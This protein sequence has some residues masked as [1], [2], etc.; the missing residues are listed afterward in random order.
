M[1]SALDGRLEAWVPPKLRAEG[2]E[3]VR[4]AKLLLAMSWSML[5]WASVFLPV[6]YAM[7]ATTVAIS[8]AIATAGVS[9]VAPVLWW[10]EDI[11]WPARLVMVSIIEVL[12]GSAFALTGPA[13]PSLFW[14][15]AMP[16]VA[17]ALLGMKEGALWTVVSM[18]AFFVLVALPESWFGQELEGW[19]LTVYWCM[20]A[21]SGLILQF[22]LG[23]SYE[24][25]KDEMRG[26]LEVARD[27]AAD[28]HAAARLVLDHVNEGLMIVGR[29]GR[30]GSQS[31]SAT[32]HLLGEPTPGEPLWS[33]VERADPTAATWLELGWDGLVDGFMPPEVVLDQLP[34]RIQV[35][36]R[37]LGVAFSPVVEEDELQQVV[38]VLRDITEELERQRAEASQRELLAVFQQLLRDPGG[39]DLF[40][41]STDEMMENLSAMPAKLQMRA[42]HTLKGNA[43][44]LGLHGL[45]SVCHDVESLM[46]QGE[47]A[48][49]AGLDGVVEAWA[50][51][52]TRLA[53]LRPDRDGPNVTQEDY[54]TLF[55]AVENGVPHRQLRDYLEGWRLEPVALPLQRA[56][57]Q[58]KMLAER[59][60]KPDLEVVLD[61]DELRVDAGQ[62]LPL[63]ASMAHA[64]RNAI[65]HGIEAPEQRE[66]AGK[67]PHGRLVLGFTLRGERAV[68]RIQDDGAGIDWDT[69]RA[70]AEGAG[71]P[72]ET[73]EDLVEA[74]FAD[75]VSSKEQAD[76]TSGRGV[77]MAALRSATHR[78]G[79]TLD[80]HSTPGHGTTWS[81]SFPAD[82]VWAAPVRDQAA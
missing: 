25:V 45:A 65:D 71:L 26:K 70:K 23:F 32:R 46:V 78:L 73:P 81:F 76:E 19:K 72:A 5:I 9:L 68:L 2:P 14:F 61:V 33:L 17:I 74:L 22:S 3:G 82:A 28:A 42:V 75:G 36:T 56:G 27:E 21:G 67:A 59:L 6:P 62:W 13:S 4:L 48:D 44:M 79:G 31:S 51:F 60:G 52:R 39:L 53:A 18:A 16:L 63:W 12:V 30:V 57:R 47:D 41:D 1:L 10:T 69:I 38:V 11:K 54:I 66:R 8:V 64:L 29:D 7:G 80:V 24:Y 58:A 77:G 34:D 35:G 43:S 40:L 37:T 55:E 49:A 15:F 50:S 20:C